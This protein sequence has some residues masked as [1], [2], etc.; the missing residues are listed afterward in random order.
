M[1][2]DS[3]FGTLTTTVN[4]STSTDLNQTLHSVSALLRLK[5]MNAQLKVY[6]LDTNLK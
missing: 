3:K 5:P 6:P 1:N 2:I 4:K